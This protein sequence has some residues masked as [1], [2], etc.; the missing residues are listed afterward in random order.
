MLVVPASQDVEH[1]RRE[2]AVTGAT[3][4]A[5]VVRFSHLFA[6][7]ARRTGYTARRATELQRRLVAED[8]VRRA[9]LAVMAESAQRPGFVRALLRFIS[10][11]ERATVEPPGWPAPCTTGPGT[12]RAPATPGR[13]GSSTAATG[14]AWRR[15]GWSTTTCS[16]GDRCPRW[17][18]GPRRGPPRRCSSTASTT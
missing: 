7:I 1:A 12:G 10:E 4:G 18:P 13:W 14:R 16:R 11:L 9:E 6:L 15:R 3:F 2:L 17:R 5:R 8:A